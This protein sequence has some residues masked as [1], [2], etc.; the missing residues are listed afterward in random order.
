VRQGANRGAK[1][2]RASRDVG[3]RVPRKNKKAYLPI[4]KKKRRANN[5]RSPKLEMR[6][7]E[8]GCCGEEAVE[9][10]GRKL[11]R[12]QNYSAAEGEQGGGRE[13]VRERRP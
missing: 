7:K 2:N 12:A 10:K 1:R 3:R 13:T 6:E 5:N 11:V 8:E 4:N 9:K